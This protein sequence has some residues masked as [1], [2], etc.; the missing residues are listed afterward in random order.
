MSDVSNVQSWLQDL[1]GDEVPD[2]EVTPANVK[3]LSQLRSL[4]IEAE[5]DTAVQIAELEKA[6]AEYDGETERLSAICDRVGLTESCLQ[7]PL[8]AY[9]DVLV[10]VCDKLDLDEASTTGITRAISDL[11][12]NRAVRQTEGHQSRVEL[13]K[14][15][16]GALELYGALNRIQT[17]LETAE[18]ETRRNTATAENQKKKLGFVVAKEKEYQK[19][20]EKSE[21]A[22]IK[23][24]ATEQLRHGNIM[25]L[26]MELEKLMEEV[27]PLQAQLESYA[28]LPPSG[29]LAQV[30]IQEAEKLLGELTNQVV[31]KISS[32]H[33]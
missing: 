29:E 4:N 31:Q 8:S 5:E 7:G 32:L 13:E 12:V 9:L 6:R 11:L 3:L 17:A 22:L 1:L 2:W 15:K 16:N 14:V 21:M 25:E 28:S 27:E 18:I 24:G 20:M 26:K 30:K 19:T 23:N 33:V 10:D